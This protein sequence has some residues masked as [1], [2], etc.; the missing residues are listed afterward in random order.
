MMKASSLLIV[1]ML[2]FLFVTWV[3]ADQE[4]QLEERQKFW[5]PIDKIHPNIPPQLPPVPPPLR[6]WRDVM[7]ENLD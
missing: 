6:T 1:A 7:A 3:L 5:I 2:A 4:V